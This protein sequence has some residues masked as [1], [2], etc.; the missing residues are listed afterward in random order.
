MP[1]VFASS[2][3]LQHLELRFYVVPRG[4][5]GAMTCIFSLPQEFQ[6]EWLFRSIETSLLS[7]ILSIVWYSTSYFHQSVG[8]DNHGKLGDSLLYLLYPVLSHLWLTPSWALMPDVSICC[9]W[10][11]DLASMFKCD[12]LWFCKSCKRNLEAVSRWRGSPS[13][14]RVDLFLITLV[15][16]HTGLTHL[17]QF[18]LQRG[19]GDL[20]LAVNPTL[21]RLARCLQ[22]FAVT[23]LC[24][25]TGQVDLKFRW[26][27]T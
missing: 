14:S 26:M 11:R 3:N 25:F 19:D 10:A 27:S 9:P 4:D 21:R 7:N 1:P 22:I 13:L 20:I 23:R 24:S 18:G 5:S 2:S 6:S 8:A 15:C 12:N 16:H 17:R